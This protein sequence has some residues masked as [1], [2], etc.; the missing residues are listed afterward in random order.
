M[1]REG[2]EEKEKETSHT[3]VAQLLGFLVDVFQDQMFDHLFSELPATPLECFCH[4]NA[5]KCAF[6]LCLSR[7]WLRNLQWE[8][9]QF[10]TGGETTPTAVALH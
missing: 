1:Q 8:H 7:G 2:E 6:L 4:F 9:Q 3:P 10:V 5:P